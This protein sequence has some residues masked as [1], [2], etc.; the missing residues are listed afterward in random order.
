MGQGFALV[1]CFL[2]VFV[3][4]AA[5][6]FFCV[7]I[8]FPEQKHRFTAWKR[9]CGV[10]NYVQKH[11]LEG[12]KLFKK[13]QHGIGPARNFRIWKK[14]LVVSVDNIFGGLAKSCE[15]LFVDPNFVQD[16]LP[17]VVHDRM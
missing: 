12:H 9:C 11:S 3:F 14:A 16:L 8:N 4:G 1:A 2:F 13:C 10:Y 5:G 15:I 7:R 6:V 17:N